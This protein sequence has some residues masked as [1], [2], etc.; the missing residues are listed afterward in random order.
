MSNAGQSAS[1]KR[2][3]AVA[4]ERTKRIDEGV[5]ALQKL[6]PHSGEG[7]EVFVM[8][9]I[10]EQCKSLQLQI[11]DLSRSR[12]KGD[13]SAEHVDIVDEGCG[14]ITSQEMLNEHL[15][16]ML[17]DNPSLPLGGK[18]HLFSMPIES[19]LSLEKREKQF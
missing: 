5:D 12:L 18:H 10:I 7:D 3:A 17:Q 15:G 16:K 13:S 1:R 9:H 19:S 4:A 6:F 11:K 14:R 2:T 8:N